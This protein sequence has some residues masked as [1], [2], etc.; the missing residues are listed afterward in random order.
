M[1]KIFTSLCA[2]LMAGT[3]AVSAQGYELRTLTFEDSDLGASFSAGKTGTGEFDASAWSDLIDPTQYNG[4]LLYTGSS[5]WW[6]DG[7][8]TELYHTFALPYWGGGHAISNY[9]CNDL[10]AYGDYTKQLT[11]YKSDEDVLVQTGGGHN[12][13]DNFA[14]HFGYVSSY[15]PNAPAIE[16][17][18]G[19]ERVIDHMY[20]N[21]TTYLLNQYLTGGGFNPP[22]LTTSWFRIKATG[23]N[24]SNVET[25]TI[26]FYLCQGNEL[27]NGVID[28]WTE[29]DMTGLGAVASVTLDIEASEDMIGDYGMN[30]PAYFAYD[31]VAVRFPAS[32]PAE[33]SYTRSGL[34]AGNFGTICLPY[35]VNEYTGATFFKVVA[36]NDEYVTL[37]EVLSLNAG[38]AYIFQATATELTCTYSGDGVNTPVAASASNVLQGVFE[39]ETIPAGL[40]FLHDNLL[41]CSTGEQSVGANRAYLTDLTPTDAAPVPGRRRINMPMQPQTPTGVEKVQSDKV[42]STKVLINGQLYIM[43]DGKTYTATGEQVK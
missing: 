42:Q 24:A 33:T 34:T 1:R 3:M 17:A 21:N 20:V 8:N 23:Y 40:W 26:Y 30:P 6:H 19:V 12:G 31:D 27:G 25:G 22:A 9:A 11:V 37:E 7:G 41:W 5:I 38:E 35:D 15:T 36:R 4:E 14:I 29:W 10:T 39:E 16:F 32:A 18:D 13:S 2:L 28:E 43:R